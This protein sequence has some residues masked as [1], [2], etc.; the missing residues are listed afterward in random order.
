VS[1]G[2]QPL[3][4]A[5]AS[6]RRRDLLARLGLPFDVR[7]VEIDEN[8]GGSRHLQVIAV[9]IARTK[10]EAS[11]LQDTESQILTADTVVALEGRIFGKPVDAREARTML[12]ALRGRTHEVVT[13][14]ALMPAGKR[15]PLVRNPLTRVKMRDYSD[16]DIEASLAR[17]DSLDK[18]GAYAIQDELF[19]PAESYE[20][21][22]CN[23]VG[24]PLWSTTELLSKSGTTVEPDLEQLLPQCA[25]CP[26][27][28]D[29]P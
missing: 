22:Y 8:P 20:G 16:A 27:R 3:V 19:R 28:P 11:R 17:G 4:L 6:P 13:A 15:S 25:T 7:P 26:L 12:R 9:R 29:T 10:A 21:C 18:A 23:V 5:S 14:V 24:L 1:K 2:A